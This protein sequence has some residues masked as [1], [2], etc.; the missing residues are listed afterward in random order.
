M[1]AY[2]LKRFLMLI[3]ILFTVMTLV[4]FLLRL[5]PGDPVDFILQENA[6]PEARAQ[7]IKAHHFDEPVWQQYKMYLSEMFQ[8]NFGRSYFSNKPVN[9]LIAERYFS[10]MYLAIT[11]VMW[12]LIFAIPLGIYSAVKKGSRFDQGTLVFSLVGI[13]VPT[14]YLGP[15]LALLFS[16]HLDLFPLSGRELPGSIFLPSITLGMAMAAILTRIS[17]ASLLEVLGLDYVRTARA[18]GLSSFKVVAKHAFRTALIPVI[19]ILGLQFGTLLA[20]AVV[21]EKI[22]SWPGL[23]SLLLEAISRRDYALVQGCVLLISGTYVIVN[24]FTD[25]VYVFVDPRVREGIT[26]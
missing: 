19:A 7:L 13:S 8:G 5:I 3:P 26:K 1:T 16:I 14:F 9:K 2:F 17:R 21:T 6:L 24:L 18:K 4:F 11:A 25:V 23:G 12:A 20:G 22:F 15:L 10:T